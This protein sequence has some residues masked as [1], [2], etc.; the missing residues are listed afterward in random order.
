[1][2]LTLEQ[3]LQKGVEAHKAGQAQEADKYYTAIL[4]ANP[5]HPDANHNM[6]ALA[7]GVGK[8]EAALPFF[9]TALEVNQTIGQYW[10]SYINALI[11]L[12]RLDD[13]KAVFNQ[14]K[15][16]GVKGDEFE[17]LE[18]KLSNVALIEGDQTDEDVL[19]KAIELREN[20]KYDEAI[21]FL[22]DRINKFPEDPRLPAI[23]SHCYILNDNL[24]Q[25]KVYIDKSKNINPN[26][27]LV[28]WNETRLLLKEMKGDE[29]LKVAEKT[30]KLFPNDVEG[31][32][33]LGMCLRATGN[34]DESLKYLNQAIELNPNY[35]EALIHKGL[36]NLAQGDKVNALSGLEKAHHLK[37]HIKQIWYL[38]LN[39]KMEAKDFEACISIAEEMLLLNPLDEIIIANIALCYQKLQKYEQVV[40]FYKKALDIKPD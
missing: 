10:L 16:K 18:S 28:G 12:D 9:K 19:E 6:G 32:G 7:V 3:A 34:L 13:A 15:S 22:K 33:V 4:K 14:A 30:N 36:I 29:A 37:P 31:I 25:A 20:G 8:V 27:A 21:D 11:K 26:I 35:A 40:V 24:D 2:E 23:L 38:V 1:M 39:L 17:Q 5:K